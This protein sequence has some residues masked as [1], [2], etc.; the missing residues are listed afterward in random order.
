MWKLSKEDHSFLLSLARKTIFDHLHN[1]PLSPPGAIP[2]GLLLE[3]CG[4]FVTLTQ[5][6]QL[7][8][9]IGYTAAL[10][11]LYETIM[12][13]AV[14]AATRDPRFAPLQAEELPRTHI[15]ISVLSPMFEVKDVNEIVAGKHGLMISRG[16]RRGLLLPQVA[17]EYHLTREKFL[18]Q[19]CMKAG[20]PPK[21]WKEPGT[22][23]EAFT[24]VVFG[25]PEEE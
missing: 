17:T 16:N 24:A 1:Q 3:K 12:D 25:E 22:R 20:L 21:S 2:E 18:D 14:S 10:K 19:T 9:C 15:E 8:G 7:R 23:I 13:C 6:H 11:P 5:A 4:A